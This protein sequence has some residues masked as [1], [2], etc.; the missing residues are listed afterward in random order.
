[1]DRVL[2]VFLAG[3]VGSVLRY[4]FVAGAEK[5][6]SGSFPY[7]VFGVNVIGSFLIALVMVLAASKAE[8]ITPV[9]RLTIT[10]GLIGGFTTYSAFNQD[11]LV[12]LE[13][14]HYGSA[15]LYV[16]ATLI[17]CMIA[18]FAGAWVGRRAA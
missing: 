14:K 1:V 4:L 3:G 17:V 11:T 12:M 2:L 5:L 15:L 18:G 9:M 16:S 13:K 6:G 7:G 10:T 8:T